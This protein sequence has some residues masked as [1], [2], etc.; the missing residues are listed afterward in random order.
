MFFVF[1]L[2]W[3]LSSFSFLKNVGGHFESW[4]TGILGPVALHGLSQG[5]MDLSWQK[6]TYQVFY[7][8]YFLV[9]SLFWSLFSVLSC[10][11][12][13]SS[14]GT[15]RWSY[16]SC[17]SNQHSLY[18]MDGCVLNCT[19][20]SAFDMAQGLIESNTTQQSFFSN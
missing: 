1:L 8:S 19:K 12:L 6:W 4:N 16:E 5:K 2:S 10:L 20:A 14:G 13:F 15:E 11:T 9:I 3:P 7:L 18:W 17:I